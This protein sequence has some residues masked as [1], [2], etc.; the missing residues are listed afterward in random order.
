[1]RLHADEHGRTARRTMQNHRKK[2]LRL[3]P[4]DRETLRAKL[5]GEILL[6]KALI[7]SR[8]PFPPLFYSKQHRGNRIDAKPARVVDDHRVFS[9]T[10]KLRDQRTPSTYVGDKANR[11]DDVNALVG[12]RE[13]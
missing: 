1:M 8:I 3:C 6:K 2:K 12:I 13:T 11:D 9:N 10:A 7:G 4:G 5:L